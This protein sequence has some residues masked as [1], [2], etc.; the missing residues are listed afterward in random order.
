MSFNFFLIL[1]IGSIFQCFYDIFITNRISK[2]EA[3]KCGY[4]CEKCGNWKCFYHYCKKQKE[5]L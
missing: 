3:K 1:I 5:G 4:D 2:K